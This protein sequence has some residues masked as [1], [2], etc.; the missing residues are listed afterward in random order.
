[1]VVGWC[2]QVSLEAVALGLLVVNF[3]LEQK[4]VLGWKQGLE[5]L[6]VS[7]HCM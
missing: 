3:V 2:I 1:V 5:V 4:H 7:S 6:K